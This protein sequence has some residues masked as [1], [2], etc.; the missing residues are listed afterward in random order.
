MNTFMY[1][2]TSQKTISN[3]LE[4]MTYFYATP[5]DMASIWKALRISQ[6]LNGK[7]VDV[8]IQESTDLP[9][10]IL[11]LSILNL[12]R[13]IIRMNDDFSGKITSGNMSIYFRPSESN[14]VICI[15]GVTY[16]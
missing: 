5:Y 9:I 2:F 10:L 14:G 13:C 1:D 6:K 3:P 16:R 11:P 7:D 8:V 15:T 4:G 12:G